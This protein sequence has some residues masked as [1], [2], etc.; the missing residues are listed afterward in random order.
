MREKLDMTCEIH[1]TSGITPACAGKTLLI[2]ARTMAF[3]D[4]PRVCGKNSG[5]ILFISSNQGSPPRVREKLQQ[6]GLHIPSNRITP[7][8]AGKTFSAAI[9][10]ICPKDHPRVC[11][12]N[13]WCSGLLSHCLGSPPRVR[14]K[15]FK[16]VF[17]L[18]YHGITPACAGKTYSWQSSIHLLQ[19]HP[20]VCGKNVRAIRHVSN[21]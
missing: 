13:F 18:K 3:W 12:K 19:D 2:K 11:G 5:T 14:E 20:R 10:P 6:F 15:R 17:S 16:R 7:A 1:L 21:A 8:C 9:K 4:H